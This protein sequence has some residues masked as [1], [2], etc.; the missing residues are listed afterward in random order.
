MIRTIPVV[1]GLMALLAPMRPLEAQFVVPPQSAS[2]MPTAI[3]RALAA[4][5]GET[6]SLLLSSTVQSG[7][8][9]IQDSTPGATQTYSGSVV[10]T[11]TWDL[12]NNRV[13]TIYAY[14]SQPFTSSTSTLAS[15]ALEASALGGTGS[16]NGVWT[17]FASTVDG[18]GTAVTLSQ[19]LARGPTKKIIDASER[20]TVSMRLNTT[21][22]YLQ[23]GLYTGI[24][25][26]GA[27]VQ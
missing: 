15:S 18:H 21:N 2:V 4:A 27:M 13:V 26:F 6:F 11:P 22:L 17:A 10:L 24:V 3:S 23:P 1:C 8:L 14:V 12:N 16:A 9:A 19:V 25:T 20:L 7:A 5:P